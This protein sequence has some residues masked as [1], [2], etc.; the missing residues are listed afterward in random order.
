MVLQK[1]QWFSELGNPP[2][3]NSDP[4]QKKFWEQPTDAG[5]IS[6]RGKAAAAKAKAR[7]MIQMLAD[8]GITEEVNAL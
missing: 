1:L 8:R 6:E 2:E 3:G 7:T 4:T 5:S